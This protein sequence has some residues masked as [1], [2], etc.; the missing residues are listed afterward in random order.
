VAKIGTC[1][2]CGEHIYDLPGHNSVVCDSCII[3][4]VALGI[5]PE[6]CAAS[7]TIKK[8][9]VLRKQWKKD[10]T[11]QN[12]LRKKCYLKDKCNNS[13][14]PLKVVEIPSCYKK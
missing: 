1:R 3:E 14:C 5:Y 2:R 10:G 6:Y 12:R 9:K 11:W 7:T 8:A 13:R 4:E